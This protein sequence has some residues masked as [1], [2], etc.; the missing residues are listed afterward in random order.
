MIKSFVSKVC[1]LGI[2][3]YIQVIQVFLHSMVYI[4]DIPQ[5]GSKKWEVRFLTAIK[6]VSPLTLTIE[7]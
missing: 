5:L 1:K 6:E 4:G 2:L 3:S 7:K